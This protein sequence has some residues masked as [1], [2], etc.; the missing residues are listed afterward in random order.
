MDNSAIYSKTSK[1]INELKSGA[2][3]IPRDDARVLTLIDGASSVND[4][5]EMLDSANNK[6]L[7]T[8]LASLLHQGLIRVFSYGNQDAHHELL[9]DTEQ[10]TQF[11]S[12]GMIKFTQALPT[13]QVTELTLRES[14]QAWA[15]A[16]RGATI[17]EKK[18]FYTYGQKPSGFVSNDSTKALRVMVVED[19]ESLSHLLETL[20]KHKNFEVQIVKHNETIVTG[21]VMLG[22]AN[23]AYSDFAARF[24][25]CPWTSVY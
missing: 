12:D 5:S 6:K 18:G 23:G 3:N 17:L 21:A 24:Q 11:T 22:E 2:K 14:V 15:E 8:T 1:G 19:D 25:S 9:M 10:P 20:L 7:D 4:L 13:I 16:R